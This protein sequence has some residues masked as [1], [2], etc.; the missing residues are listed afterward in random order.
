LDKLVNTTITVATGLE[1]K[2][3]LSILSPAARTLVNR[4]ASNPS[5]LQQFI[6]NPEAAWAEFGEGINPVER[7]TLELL[8]EIFVPGT[9]IEILPAITMDSVW[10]S[11][12]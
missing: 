7:R 6:H 11:G 1:G 10:V 5:I 4:A 3:N 2:F 12:R 8:A 9:S